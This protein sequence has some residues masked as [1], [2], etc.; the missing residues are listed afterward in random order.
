MQ[1]ECGV[2][3][4]DKVLRPKGIPDYAG[5]TVGKNSV[6]RIVTRCIGD[7]PAR[8]QMHRLVKRAA[9]VVSR[10]PQAA[11]PGAIIKKGD[12]AIRGSQLTH[13]IGEEIHAGI[14]IRYL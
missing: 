5:M 9:S 10:A 2:Q 8:R 7:V 6:V 14:N 3:E 4:S 1:S 11:E 13:A 12:A